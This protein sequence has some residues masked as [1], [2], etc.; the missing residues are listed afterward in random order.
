MKKQ[1]T[2]N[3]SFKINIYK[4]IL[5]GILFLSFICTE[6]QAQQDK[7][8]REFVA[9]IF[10]EDY[11][12]AWRL[13]SKE[14]QKDYTSESFKVAVKSIRDLVPQL[15]EEI[16]SFMTGTR[17]YANGSSRVIY[18]YK[19]KSDVSKGVPGVL[20][21][22]HF[23]DAQSE[24]IMGIE[25]KFSTAPKQ[26]QISTSTGV[27]ESLEKEQEWIIGSRKIQINEVTLIQFSGDIVMLAIKVI[28][29]IPDNITQQQAKEI[30]LPIVKYAIEKGFLQ[31]A[32]KA[33]SKSKRKLSENI[34]VAFIRPG[35]RGGYRVQI[36]PGEYKNK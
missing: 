29:D 9:S 21:D 22:V 36:N 11:T 30:A 15:G 14:T 24:S 27:E 19:F 33:A 10:Q 3:E 6:V 8:A 1:L 4:S 13:L 25:S 23:K 17:A 18:T 12:N 31:K 16:E 5:L 32:D 34:G 20:I 28:D 26:N 7:I 35:T 2:A